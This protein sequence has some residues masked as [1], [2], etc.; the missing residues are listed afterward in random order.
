MDPYVTPTQSIWS[1]VVV[2][3]IIAGLVIMW[4]YIWV[5]APRDNP[6]RFATTAYAE[7]AEPICAAAQ[8]EINALPLGVTAQT[9]QERAVAVREGTV[10]TEQM[11]ADLRNLTTLVDDATDLAT[12]ERWFEDWEDGYLV[13]R[14]AHVERLETATIDTDPRD[15]AFLIQDRT[16]G[17]FYTRRID[18][19]ANV[20]DMASCHVPL[21]I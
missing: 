11:V 2:T 4:A 5:L 10:I 20:N 19:L 13:D 3:A 1:R 18:G 16:E 17:G 9:P 14:W 21:D 8:A 6:D 12:L 7:A 15:L